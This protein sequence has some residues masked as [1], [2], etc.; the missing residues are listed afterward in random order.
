MGGHGLDRDQDANSTGVLAEPAND[1][2]DDRAVCRP[3]A[4]RGYQGG[5]SVGERGTFKQ[6]RLQYM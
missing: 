6:L 2:Y 1:L 5:N 3:Q 4:S